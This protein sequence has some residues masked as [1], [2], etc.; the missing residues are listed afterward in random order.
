MEIVR[1]QTTTIKEYTKKQNMGDC[2]CEY[3]DWEGYKKAQKAEWEDMKANLKDDEKI[4]C[5]PFQGYAVV[6]K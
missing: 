6:K 4:I 3:V 2:T 1:K 5:D